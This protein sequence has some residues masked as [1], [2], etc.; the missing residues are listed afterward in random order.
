MQTVVG[1][2]IVAHGAVAI[3]DDGEAEQL[4]SEAR[5]CW[6]NLLDDQ[7]IPVGTLGDTSIGVRGHWVKSDQYSERI[8]GE[9]AR[10]FDL[11]IVRRNLDDKGSFWQTTAEAV[12]FESGRPLLLVDNAIPSTLGQNI[13][14]AWN[15][16]TE[17][18][19]TITASAPLLEAAE[20][21]TVLS[22][23]D[24]MDQV[25]VVPISLTI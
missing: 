8:I 11:A 1:V 25:P 19:R 24:G 17:A 6:F 21:V 3:E 16:S 5:Q 4:A 10:L 23:T 12:L 20:Q 18:G 22:V 9:Y 13:V 14:I 7:G 15:G 2:G